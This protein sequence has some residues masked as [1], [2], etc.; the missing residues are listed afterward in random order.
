MIRKAYCK[1]WYPADREA[2]LKYFEPGGKKAD[3]SLFF[4]VVPHAGWVYSG[5]IAG[6]VYSAMPKADTVIFLGT[7]HTGRGAPTSLFPEGDWEM[8]MGKIS[9][10]QEFA[11]DLLKQSR[12]LK[13]DVLAHLY[14][15]AIE[16]QLP[17]LQ[18]AGPG[19]KIV[20]IEMQDYRMSV[21]KDVAQAVA[22]TIEE[23]LRENPKSRF[24]V[25][26]STDMTHCGQAYGQLPKEGLSPG[27]FARRQDQSAV[28]EMLALNPEGLA[29]V[30]AE[31]HVTLCGLGPAAAVLEAARLLGA[32]RAH[33]MGYATSTDV[34]GP[35]S[36]LAVGYAGILATV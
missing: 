23:R 26:A 20:P 18:A 4:A 2:V 31:K 13:S 17:F 32:R 12:E 14:E 30:V 1:N 5:R 9:V 7:N 10:D 15:H 29:K 25:A 36:D 34:A 19:T 22:K 21:C 24:C 27:E 16:V 11:A 8:P 3:S 35:E 28:Q 6:A 33:L